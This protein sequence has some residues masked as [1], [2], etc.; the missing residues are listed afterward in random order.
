MNTRTAPPFRELLLEA[1]I[2]DD[3]AVG[4]NAW[5]AWKAEFGADLEL[6]KHHR[7][8]P[9]VYLR[10]QE[11]E[12]WDPSMELLRW[13][14]ERSARWNK[15]VLAAGEEL[16]RIFQ[17]HNIDVMLLKGAALYSLGLIDPGARFLAD[18]DLL[19]RPEQREL[20]INTLRDSG[21]KI[22][23]PAIHSHPDFSH[24]VTLSKGVTADEQIDL[25]TSLSYLDL[26]SRLDETLW[27]RKKAVTFQGR[28]AYSLDPSDLLLNVCLHGAAFVGHKCYWIVDAISI[29][30][31]ASITIDWDIFVSSCE[32]R[33]LGCV[34]LM[35]LR[36][37][38]NYCEAGIP[39][40]VLSGATA[41]PVSMQE[42]LESL[43]ESKP[44]RL[45]LGQAPKKLLFFFRLD[46]ELRAQG[47]LATFLR[48]LNYL[49][50]KHAIR[51]FRPGIFGLIFRSVRDTY[52]AFSQHR[53]K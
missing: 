32:Q 28:E 10:L 40:N 2:A 19:I 46:P 26:N 41:I 45:M 18:I 8:L 14:Y 16:L 38:S 29:L 3:P 34:S 31:S 22:V 51:D 7:L 9:L 30:R 53:G 48:Y 5:L 24:S 42:R 33:K 35:T 17:L 44:A 27:Q 36:Y 47:Q 50:C 25:H 39:E 23:E 43:A 21:F 1:V 20:A 49:I 37:L 11:M 6:H 4:L 52:R 15:N 12:Y 13:A